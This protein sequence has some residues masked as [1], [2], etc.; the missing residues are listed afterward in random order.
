M[1]EE[2]QKYIE[3]SPE[4]KTTIHWWDLYKGHIVKLKREF[5][6][7]LFQKLENIIKSYKIKRLYNINS[8]TNI[9]NEIYKKQGYIKYKDLATYFVNDNLSYDLAG[10]YLRKFLDKNMIKRIKRGFYVKCFY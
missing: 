8:V 9:I 7:E 10:R 1:N 2:F 4:V 3:N 5:Q 6:M